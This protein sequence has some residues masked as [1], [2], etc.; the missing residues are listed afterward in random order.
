VVVA[1]SFNPSTHKAEPGRSLEFKAKASLVYTT[2]SK[3]A[4]AIQKPI[5][6][7]TKPNHKALF[8]LDSRLSFAG[9]LFPG[10]FLN[11]VDR[12]IWKNYLT[13][14]PVPTSVPEV[15]EVT[16][17]LFLILFV[18]VLQETYSKYGKRERQM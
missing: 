15:P 2:S 1:H 8:A 5:L 11:F 4:R 17:F 18:N 7:K 9:S 13:A 6:K 16:N 3:T 14:C 10:P 12:K